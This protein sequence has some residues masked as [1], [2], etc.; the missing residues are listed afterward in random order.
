MLDFETGGV[1]ALSERG[2]ETD[3]GGF[4]SI[5]LISDK[6]VNDMALCVS[7]TDREHAEEENI[8]GTVQIRLSSY[9][10]PTEGEERHFHSA[11]EIFLCRKEAEQLHGFIGFLLAHGCVDEGA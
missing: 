8:K 2:S 10:V 4:N 5:Q 9:H 7:L 6:T 3:Y 11:L 1:V